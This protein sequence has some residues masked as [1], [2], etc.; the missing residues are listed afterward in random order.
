MGPHN[1]PARKIETAFNPWIIAT[2]VT[3]GTFMEVLDT[4]IA[5]VAL[6]HIGGSL[7]ASSEE[8]TWVL[9]SYLVANA[10]VL[11]LS[12]WLSS[13]LG[14]KRFYMGCMAIFVAS[15]MLCGMATSL[16]MLIFFRVLQGLGGGGLQ[17]SVQAIL[18]DTFP[19]EKRGMAMA[20][21]TMT[22]LV[23]PV[24]GPT[25][26]GWI[27]DSF[28]WRWI[29]YINVPVGLTGL[30]LTGLVL[31]DPEYI[32]EKRTQIQKTGLRI[33]Y[34]G[35]SLLS[36]GLAT[37]EIMLDKGQ[38]LDWFSSRFILVLGVIAFAALVSA[39]IW[40]L[41]HPEP[42]VNLRLLGERNFAVCLMITF[43]LY[44][45]LYATTVMLPQ[46]L[47]SLMGYSATNAGLVLSP[48]GLVT[49]LEVP[50]VGF[51]LTKRAD[52][53]WMIAL[54]LVFVATASFWMSTLNLEVGP[55]N[56]IWPRVLQVL[57]AGMIGVPLS[58]IIFR[59]L[60]REQ[61]GNAASLYA[62]T[63]NEASSVGVAL[64]TT[65][66]Q[67]GSQEHQ[68]FLASHISQYNPLAMERSSQ[69]GAA[70]RQ[71]L[72]IGDQGWAALYATV[73][74]QAAM[75][76]YLDNFRRFGFVTLLIVPLVLLLKR[77]NIEK[78]EV[79]ELH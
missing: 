49:M 19:L 65:L 43:G 64:V 38:E 32:T 79:S 72:S 6:P 50:I 51:L 8:S 63:R 12:G 77:S 25:L 13:V 61:S 71:G 30:A 47:Q 3:L 18:A 16:G 21:Y 68:V 26:G 27:T 35:I 53:R 74:K 23:A 66:L 44:A 33:D 20:V 39:V 69:F 31:R 60:P 4:S 17:P 15:S 22:I 70:L 67:R 29:F 28:S 52:P 45:M 42:I 75:L 37:L 55:G 1:T 5:N 46:L 56:V 36:L 41:R 14:R 40:E 11:P 76:A 48:A 10:V 34:L 2:A 54:G 57:G 9:T 58:T 73:Q 59:Y 78:V 24:L 62:L 7:S